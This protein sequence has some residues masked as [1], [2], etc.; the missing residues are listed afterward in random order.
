MATREFEVQ[1][2]LKAYRKGLISDELFAEQM[3]ELGATRNGDG[4]DVANVFEHKGN[5]VKML[6][7]TARSNIAVFTLP[8][9]YT[10]DRENAHKG[11]QIIYVIDGC[12]TARVSGKEQDIK[13]GDVLMIPAGAPHTL[14]T[15]SDP[16]FGFTVFAPPEDIGG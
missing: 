15:G 3:Q 5:P 1:Q 6:Q 8:A 7:K 4:L 10:N 16:F 14:R 9:G 12:A 13:A 2:V 11:D